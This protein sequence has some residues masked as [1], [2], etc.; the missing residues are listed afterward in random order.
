MTNQDCNGL[1]DEILCRVALELE[2]STLDGH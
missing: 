1:G 2:V